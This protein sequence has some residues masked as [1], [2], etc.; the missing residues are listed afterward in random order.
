MYCLFFSCLLP[1]HLLSVWSDYSEIDQVFSRV[2][3]ALKEKAAVTRSQLGQVVVQ[4]YKKNVSSFPVEMTHL[5]NIANIR[6]LL[7]GHMFA[8]PSVTKPQAFR[9]LT[10]PSDK[11][12]KMQV[13][14]RS[15]EDKWGCIDR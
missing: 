11:K 15:Y 7:A 13:Q 8:I 14:H 3:V 10:D 9:F 1:F 12:I 2:S 5:R 4:A 6:D